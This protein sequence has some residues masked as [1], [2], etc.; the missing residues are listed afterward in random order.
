MS[1][2]DSNFGFVIIASLIGL[3]VWMWICRMIVVSALESHD[4]SKY[5][6]ANIR[7]QTKLLTAIARAQGVSQ[8]DINKIID[9][10][11]RPYMKGKKKGKQPPPP[12][13]FTNK[14][15]T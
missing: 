9:D 10:A 7:V 11:N 1:P 14:S 8:E 5:I 13:A 6:S 15:N 12:D 3:I 2:S 4:N